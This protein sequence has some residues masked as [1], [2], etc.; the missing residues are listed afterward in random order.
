[1]RG[2]HCLMITWSNSL[3]RLVVSL[4]ITRLGRRSTWSGWH[5]TAARTAT[6]WHVRINWRGDERHLRDFDLMD[7]QH[8]CV[9]NE[10]LI[11]TPFE[12]LCYIIQNN[13]LPSFYFREDD[14]RVR[15]AHVRMTT[16]LLTQRQLTESPAADP[17]TDTEGSE[18]TTESPSWNVVELD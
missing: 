10:Q 8:F 18:A 9:T 4:R 12:R 14:G 7:V 11:A 5:G 1:M 6:G 13:E 3:Q 2:N 17:S 15:F 16:R